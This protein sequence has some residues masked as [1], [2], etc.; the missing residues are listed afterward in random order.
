[1]CDV[2]CDCLLKSEGEV[3][4][5]FEIDAFFLS[6]EIEEFELR[7]SLKLVLCFLHGKIIGN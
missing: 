5:F 3:N 4:K 1:M 2:V 7:Y 6:F